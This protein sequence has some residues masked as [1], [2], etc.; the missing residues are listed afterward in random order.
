[1]T[2]TIDEILATIQENPGISTLDIVRK[3]VSED[4]PTNFDRCYHCVRVKITYLVNRGEVHRLDT[5]RPGRSAN[6]YARGAA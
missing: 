5:H 4:E 2:P 6:W 1:M 3:F